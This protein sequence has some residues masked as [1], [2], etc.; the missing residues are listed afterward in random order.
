ML[1]LGWQNSFETDLK[2]LYNALLH[3][4]QRGNTWKNNV[5]FLST[6]ADVPEA[7]SVAGTG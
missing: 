7:R 3:F 6:D 4:G 1:G 5:L 2:C